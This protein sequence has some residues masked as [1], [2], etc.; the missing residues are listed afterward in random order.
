MATQGWLNQHQVNALAE[1]DVIQVVWS[2]GNGGIYRVVFNNSDHD[3]Y[4]GVKASAIGDE[5]TL[6]AAPHA[7]FEDCFVGTIYPCSESRFDCRVRRYTPGVSLRPYQKVWVYC[8]QTGVHQGTVESLSDKKSAFV[9][10]D[11]GEVQELGF[12]AIVPR[13]GQSWADAERYF[14][15]EMGA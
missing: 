4:S 14:A 2:G 7:Y 3:I 8:K 9:K 10:I 5:D 1:G 6:A 11:G 13:V 15:D 12:N